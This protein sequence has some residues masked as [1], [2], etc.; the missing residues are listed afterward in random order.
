MKNVAFQD[1]QWQ[2]FIYLTKKIPLLAL[3]HTFLQEVHKNDFNPINLTMS[4]TKKFPIG[5]K[6]YIKVFSI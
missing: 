2:N 1:G 4:D 5:C 3:L 6:W